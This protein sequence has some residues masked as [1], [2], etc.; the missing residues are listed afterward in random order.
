MKRMKA[1]KERGGDV[2]QKQQNYECAFYAQNTFCWTK[3][4]ED[5]NK[6]Y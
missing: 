5:N 2:L 1:K 6:T 3:T 4:M